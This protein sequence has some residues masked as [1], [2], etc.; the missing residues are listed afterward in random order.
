MN[1]IKSLIVSFL[2]TVSFTA[3]KEE[4]VTLEVIDELD[5]DLYSLILDTN[6][7][8]NDEYTVKD[9]TTTWN[10]EW[11]TLD[12]STFNYMQELHPEIEKSVFADYISKN[13]TILNL[14]STKF[15]KAGKVVSLVSQEAY[16]NRTSF[17]QDYPNSNGLMIFR[18]IGYNSTKNQAIVEFEHIEIHGAGYL[19]YL[20]KTDNN[21]WEVIE[22]VMWWIS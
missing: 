15:Q 3:C 19:V 6:W 1:P 2:I 5:Y 12:S 21:E 7:L 11:F 4:T 20:A 9:E 22:W 8:N 10:Y 16:E 17:Y 13:E 18:R 14:D